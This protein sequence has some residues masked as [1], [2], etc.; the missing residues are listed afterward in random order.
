MTT[1]SLLDQLRPWFHKLRWVRTLHDVATRDYSVET[2]NCYRSMRILSVLHSSLLSSIHPGTIDA[3]LD[4][5]L[6]SL[7]PF[8]RILEQWLELGRLQD[9][10]NEFI[11]YRNPDCRKEDVWV[12]VFKQRH[13]QEKLLADN[14]Q[15]ISLFTNLTDKILVSGKSNEILAKGRDQN[16]FCLSL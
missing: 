4:L 8:L 10:R 14:I 15:P 7:R 6:V 5:F 12:G 13:F 1:L 16:C 9:H 3:L 11:F 2:D